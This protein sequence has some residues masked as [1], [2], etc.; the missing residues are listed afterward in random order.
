MW[1]QINKYLIERLTIKSHLIRKNAKSR[2]EVCT[3]TTTIIFV[4]TMSNLQKH[5]RGFPFYYLF[6]QNDL[7]VINDFSNWKLFVNVLIFVLSRTFFICSFFFL[8]Q[9]CM[10]LEGS[11][12]VWVAIIVGIFHKYLNT[13]CYF[14]QNTYEIFFKNCFKCIL[15]TNVFVKNNN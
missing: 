4:I 6:F 10:F 7:F 2:Y 8:I 3:L 14:I 1:F 13:F 12:N 9:E 11:S 5:I 15:N